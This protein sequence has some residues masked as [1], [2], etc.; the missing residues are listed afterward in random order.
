MST[1]PLESTAERWDLTHDWSRE[2]LTSASELA[3]PP[4]DWLCQ[5]HQGGFIGARLYLFGLATAT[6]LP[7]TPGHWTVCSGCACSPGAILARVGASGQDPPQAGRKSRHSFWA[8]DERSSP[9][10]LGLGSRASGV[11][12]GW[13]RMSARAC[14]CDL[15]KGPGAPFDSAGIPGRAAASNTGSVLRRVT[16]LKS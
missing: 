10:T 1:A 6:V 7:R 5:S 14:A 8:T 9:F 16:P 2:T 15:P 13:Q 4:A 3:L 11:L 12:R